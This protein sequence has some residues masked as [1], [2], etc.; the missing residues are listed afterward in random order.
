M[1]QES[2]KVSTGLRDV[3]K[4]ESLTCTS[5][6]VRNTGQLGQIRRVFSFVHLSDGGKFRDLGHQSTD[7]KDLGDT[8]ICL[9]SS[10]FSLTYREITLCFESRKRGS[11]NW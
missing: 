2:L 5:H 6:K 4:E 10:S 1:V 11:G 3:L 8:V 9:S 7:S